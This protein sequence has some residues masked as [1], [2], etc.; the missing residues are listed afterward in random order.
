M[1]VQLYRLS[2]QKSRLL[3]ALDAITSI[4][5]YM[6]N[7]L[8]LIGSEA[9]FDIPH[10]S[11]SRK[12]TLWITSVDCADKRLRAKSRRACYLKRTKGPLLKKDHGLG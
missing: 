7:C 3:S 9:E 2:K 11:A 10:L 6:L 5:L 1:D 8:L 4:Y 12:I